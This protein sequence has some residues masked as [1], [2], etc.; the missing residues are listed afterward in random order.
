MTTLNAARSGNSSSSS[1]DEAP[2]PVQMKSVSWLTSRP[3]TMKNFF[4]TVDSTTPA[5]R[6]ATSSTN[7]LSNKMTAA[8]ALRKTKGAGKAKAIT[9]FFTPTGQF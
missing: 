1:I 7:I 3:K 9:A 4:K 2:D 5:K 6:K 8:T